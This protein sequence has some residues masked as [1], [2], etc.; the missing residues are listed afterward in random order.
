LNFIP[1]LGWMANFAL[2]L[3]G[4][5]ALTAAVFERL[6]GNIDPVLDTDMQP[7]EDKP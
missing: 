5:G 4:I 1:I 3:A 6:A 2:V 7:I